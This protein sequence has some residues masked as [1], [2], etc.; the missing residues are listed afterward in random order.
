MVVFV[1]GV[2]VFIIRVVVVFSIGRTGGG[3]MGRGFGRDGSE[4]YVG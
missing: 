4:G 1:R 2:W 3:R